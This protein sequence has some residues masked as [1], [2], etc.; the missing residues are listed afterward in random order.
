M[1]RLFLVALV[2]LIALVVAFAHPQ[3]ASDADKLF[4]GLIEALNG[5]DSAKLKAFVGANFTDEV[6][7]EQ[8]LARIGGL[9]EQGAPFEILKVLDQ[10][11][12]RY[13]ALVRDKHGDEVEFGI[14]LTADTPPKIRRIMVRPVG[15]EG[16][17]APKDYSGW[18]DL[19][20]LADEI[21]K[22]RNAPA[23]GIAV[24]HDGKAATV[25]RGVRELGKPDE[26]GPDEP[27]SIGSIGKP[28]CST[29]I[30]K[31]IE[32]GKLRWDTT[33]GEALGDFPMDDGY[34]GVTLE[35][36]MHHR[37]GIPQDMGFSGATVER[38][39]AGATDPL[40]VRE[41]YARAILSRKPISKA[42][43]SFAYSN[44]GYA[45]LAI[46]AE[47][48]LGKPYEQLVREIVFEPLGLRHSFVGTSTLPEARPNG[49]VPGP[50][51]KLEPRFLTGPLETMLV[52]A[53]GGMWMSVGDLA[54]FGA[55]HLKGLKG[56]DGLLKATTVERLH[57]GEP[58]PGGDR[59]YACGWSVQEGPVLGPIH[60]H[61][62]SN[63]TFRAE[64]GVFPKLNLAVASITNRGGESDPS[65]TLQAVMAVA[66]HYAKSN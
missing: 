4:H 1:S 39:V 61:N 58:E 65:P 59:A 25:A 38:I 12:G 45:L 21:R 48:T 23:L 14:E 8:R 24:I 47:R 66:R 62:G 6:P 55:E 3:G 9:I 63:G 22:D 57:R 42:G 53:G 18:T 56:Q 52:G 60:G 10:S 30:G 46:V 51:G 20:R 54:A 31:L 5:N 7:L 40:K 19:A 36:I 32:A 33:L 16:D 37:G 29:I 11:P 35:Q 26:V 34:R 64:L 27:W 28:I 15:D 17:V 41:N 44:A 13:R 50:S 2:A 49:H 43:T